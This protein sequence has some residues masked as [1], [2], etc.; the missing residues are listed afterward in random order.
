MARITPGTWVA[1]EGAYGTFT[2]HARR[3]DSVLL[4][5]AGVG[6]T[7]VRALLEDL[8]DHV[9]ADVL[10]RAS[11]PD[12]LVLHDEITALV[13]GRAGR[14]HEL[15][16]PR[17]AVAVDAPTLRRLVPDV[18]GRDVYVCGPQGFTDGVVSALRQ[19][20][21]PTAHIHREAFAL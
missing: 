5:G 6:I 14:L 8:P 12:D 4:I 9:H 7:P 16:G 18:A 21:V 20:R 11:T 2:D 10:V 3:N 19:C 17:S 1:I 15:V 13:E